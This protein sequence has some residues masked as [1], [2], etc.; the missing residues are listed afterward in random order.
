LLPERC[1]NGSV[2]RPTPAPYRYPILC[3]CQP[4]DYLGQIRTMILANP[5]FFAIH[6]FYTMFFAY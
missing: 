5:L 3:Y 1:G 2:A 6:F 4:D